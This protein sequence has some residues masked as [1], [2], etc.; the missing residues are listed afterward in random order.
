MRIL[1]TGADGFIGRNF[2]W[3]LRELPDVVCVP[4]TRSNTEEWLEVEIARADAIVHLAG[5]NRPNVAA[6]F[7]ATNVGLTTRVCAAIKKSGKPI[8]LIFASSAQ[9]TLPNLYGA[10]KLEAEQVLEQLVKDTGSPV[11]VYRL[12]NVFGKWCRPNYNSVVATFCHNIAN[13]LPIRIDDASASLT[14]VYIDDVVDEFLRVLGAPFSG[15]QYADVGPIFN[16]TVGQ[17]AALIDSFKFSRTS[18]LTQCVGIGIERALYATFISYLPPSRFSY[19]LPKYSDS[20]GDFVEILKTQSSGQFS[21]FTARPGVTRGNHYHHTKT[22]KFLVL[23][24]SALFEFRNIETGERHELRTSGAT[25]EVVET[26][27]GW[28]HNITNIGD[29]EMVVVLWAN[30]VFDKTRPD[31]VACRV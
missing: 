8:P 16:V 1:V 26:V 12:P 15:Y 11:V 22:E 10:S 6:E 29:D 3:R 27:P 7:R 17:L 23:K 9:A 13:D 24:G 2:R 31:T 5:V 21:Y 4:Y 14:L 30:E 18:L 28:A 19:E 20:R 25:A